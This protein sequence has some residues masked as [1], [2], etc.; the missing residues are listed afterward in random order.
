MRLL[1]RLALVFTVISLTVG[2]L[3]AAPLSSA[4]GA[5]LTAPAE[6]SSSGLGTL[7]KVVAYGVAVFG[8]IR[9]RDTGALAT[10]YA[11][12]AGNATGDYTAGIQAGGPD[13]E[14]NTRAGNDAWKQGVNDAVAKDRFVKGVAGSQQKFLDNATKLGPQRYQQ[15]VGNAKDSWA[16][17]TQ[18]YLDLLKSLS[19]PPPGPRR[20]PQNLQ[21][22][23]MVAQEL[24]K[25]KESM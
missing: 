2:P 16:S 3:A 22:A 19:L 20:S 23:N 10:K 6:S 12:R 9:I 13:W 21:R 17:G 5:R 18:P 25:K 15:G 24:G 11:Q 14:A 8:A 4:A 1:S 7:A